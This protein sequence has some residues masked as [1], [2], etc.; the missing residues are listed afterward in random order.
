MIDKVKEACT[1]C[2]AC[3]SV[4]P[5]D[6]IQMLPD[7]EGFLRP[8]IDYDRCTECNACERVCPAL[9]PC[10]VLQTTSPKVIAAW[11]KDEELRINSTSGGIFSELAK[12]ILQQGGFVFGARY[13]NDFTVE[14]VWID[15]IDDLRL[16]RQSKY[17]QSDMGHIFREVKRLLKTDRPVLFC[18]SPCHAAGLLNFF[19]KAP[20][21]LIV[22]DYICRGTMSPMVFKGYLSDL[23]KEY[24]SGVKKIQ[25]K[26]KDIGWNQFCTRI[27]FENGEVYLKDRFA[28]DYMRGYL[29]YNLYIRPSCYQC[30]FKG[31]PRVSDISLGDFWGISKTRPHLDENKGTSIIM[32]NTRKGIDFF[33]SCSN[34]FETEVCSINEA[35]SGNA[36]I[37]DNIP[38]P[39]A[40]NYFFNHFKK[41]GF[42]K[43]IQ[44]YDRLI[45]SVHLFSRIKLKLKKVFKR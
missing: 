26:N 39:V 13:R 11:S 30:K 31:L 6:A 36:C 45:W 10:K 3:Y 2:N 17:M 32:L 4:C 27:D 24:D 37:H 9:V 19:K 33:E 21:N 41:H 18:G 29:R 20:E 43:S 42:Q 35:V 34:A 15:S 7:E 14:H 5:V 44:K 8:V 12:K 28:D 38:H 16:L 40:R 1:G 23:E 25:F 22:C